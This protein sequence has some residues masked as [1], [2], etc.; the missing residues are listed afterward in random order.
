MSEFDELKYYLSDVK[1]EWLCLCWWVITYLLF[2]YDKIRH[3]Y[4]IDSIQLEIEF[5]YPYF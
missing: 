1:C 5:Y 4:D 2:Y 3:S